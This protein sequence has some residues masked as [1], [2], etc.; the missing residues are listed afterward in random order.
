[1]CRDRSSERFWLVG[2]TSAARGCF[3]TPAWGFSEWIRLTLGGSPG[4][5][6][7]PAPS[8]TPGSPTTPGSPEQ[9]ALTPVLQKFFEVMGVLLRFLRHPPG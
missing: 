5:P 4:T 2:V 3:F 9:E 1:M 6:A 7:T 8:A